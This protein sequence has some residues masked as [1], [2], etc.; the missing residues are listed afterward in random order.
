MKGLIKNKIKTQ[1]YHSANKKVTN[2]TFSVFD[3]NKD[4]YI[5]IAEMIIWVYQFNLF[6]FEEDCFEVLDANGWEDQTAL[7]MAQEY[8]EENMDFCYDSCIDILNVCYLKEFYICPQ[9][10]GQKLSEYL[11]SLIPSMMD[12]YFG[13]CSGIITTYIEP[14]REQVSLEELDNFVE[15]CRKDDIDCY[16]KENTE[17]E[18]IMAKPLIKCGFRR[19]SNERKY[20]CSIKELKSK[21]NKYASRKYTNE[22]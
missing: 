11:L 1:I 20:A 10:R 8:F 14:Y 9:F 21:T 19:L 13:I 16:T 5:D 7:E 2:V 3:Y 17:L 15:K 18:Q 6:D 4:D 22:A 12:S